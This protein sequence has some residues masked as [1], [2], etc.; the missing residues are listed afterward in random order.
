M[1]KPRINT[2]EE[3][4]TAIGVSRP[5]LSRF[6]QDPSLVKKGT[7]ARIEAGLAQ[8]EYVPNFFATRL[9]RKSTG[10]IGVIIPYLN[11]LFFTKLLEAVEV[12]AMEAGLTVITQCSHSDPAIEARAAETF[13]SMNVDGALVAPLGDHSDRGVHLRLKSRLPFVLMDS[14]PKKMPNVDFVGTNHMQS[15]GLITEYLCRVGDPPVFLAMP[16]VNFNALEREVAY[17][18]QMEKLGF[19]PQV[20][21]VEAVKE[22]GYFEQHGEAVLDAEFAQGKLTDRSIL[23]VNDRVAIGAIR[24]AARHGLVPGR[25]A[26]GGLRIAGHD[27]YPLCPFLNPALT[28]V[29][30]DTDAIGKKAVSRI[31]Q[32]IRGEV[33]DDV[34]EITLFDGTL[35]LRESA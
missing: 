27:D 32:I 16:R 34:P 11:D 10:I 5:T 8:V 18:A 7:V 29:A 13:M 9:N 33:T 26:K 25:S 3:L 21:G 30:Q 1:S 28:T 2:M 6:F 31:L 15:T 19:E 23:C 20:I 24:A 12:A 14:R 4:S 22:S 35:K 17:I